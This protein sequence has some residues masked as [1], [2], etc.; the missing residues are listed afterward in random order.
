ML[1][2]KVVST[3]KK[4]IDFDWNRRYHYELIIS[5]IHRQIQGN[6]GLKVIYVHTMFSFVH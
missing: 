3:D 1:E 4:K 5:N 6:I 2:D